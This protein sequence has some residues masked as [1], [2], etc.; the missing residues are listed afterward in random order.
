[1]TVLGIDPGTISTGWAVVDE[2][3]IIASGTLKGD[4]DTTPL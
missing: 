2:F 1:M 4:K 3:G